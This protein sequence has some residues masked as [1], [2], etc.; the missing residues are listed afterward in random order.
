MRWS[1]RLLRLYLRTYPREFRERF[2][3]DL[4]TDFLQLLATR[5]RRAAWRYAL[6]DMRRAVPMTHSDDQRLRQ[7]RFAMT[8][9]TEVPRHRWHSMRA[10]PCAR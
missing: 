9:G 7:R 4:E 10:M 8:L 2:G 6:S 1:I 3:A 5:G